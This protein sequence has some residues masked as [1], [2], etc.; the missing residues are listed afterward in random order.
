MKI[1]EIVQNIF[2]EQRSADPVDLASRAGSRYGTEKNYGYD[3]SE[4]VPGQYIPLKSYNDDW[5]DAMEEVFSKIYQSLGLGNLPRDKQ[6][7]LRK[8]IDAESKTQK[9][10]PIKDLYATQPFVRIEDK[11]ILKSKLQNN[12]SITVVDFADRLFIRDGHHAVL[13]ARLRGEKNIPALVINLDYLEDK[14]L[15]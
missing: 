10:V 6:T 9:S 11:N 4:T 5:V 7:Q 15:T 1:D 3:S 8:R 2:L 14:Y 12:K 13:A